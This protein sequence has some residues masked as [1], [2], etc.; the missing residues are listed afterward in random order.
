[1][2][3]EGREMNDDARET[4]EDGG[5]DGRAGGEASRG[6]VLELRGF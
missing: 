3:T 5:G 4:I 2:R 6:E 1:M